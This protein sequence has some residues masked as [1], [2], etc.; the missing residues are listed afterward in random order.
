MQHLGRANIPLARPLKPAS[1]D[2]NWIIVGAFGVAVT[3]AVTSVNSLDEVHASSDR[4][5][6]KRPRVKGRRGVTFALQIVAVLLGF[7][8]ERGHTSP[9]VD[10]SFTNATKAIQDGVPTVFCALGPGPAAPQTC[11]AKSHALRW[12]TARYTIT[13]KSDFIF[14]INDYCQTTQTA[15]GSGTCVRAM[16]R[17]NV[18]RG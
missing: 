15:H 14:T 9:R 6:G 13:S 8:V 3:E 18:R 7:I 10:H 5:R 11:R 16:L 12:S 17:Y 2:Y 1:Q 4:D